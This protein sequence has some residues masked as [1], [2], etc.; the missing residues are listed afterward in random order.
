MIK[1]LLPTNWI[2]YNLQQIITPLIEAKVAIGTLKNL[3][4]QRSWVENLQELELKREIAGTS[5]IEGAD[6]TEKEFEIALSE[7]TEQLLTRSQKQASAAQKAYKWIATRPL[8]YPISK[9]L[10]NNIHRLIVKDVDDDHCKPGIIRNQDENV[11]YGQPRHRGATG[12]SECNEAFSN[13][14]LAIQ[15]DFKKHDPLI[16]AFAAHYHLA[17]IHPYQDGNGRT[18]RA[19]EALMLQRAGL[20]DICFVPM[21]NYYFDEK[22]TYLSTLAETRSNNHDLTSFIKFGLNGIKI[23]TARIVNE[24]KIMNQKGLY[25]N[26]MYDLFKR[27][28]NKKRR[29]IVT[30]QIE[31]LKLLL[32]HESIELEDAYKR[33]E[34][35]YSNLKTSLTSFTRDLGELIHLGAITYNSD[36]S[37]FH[38]NL[39]WPMEMS[40]TELYEK[41]KNL[42]KAKT[43]KFL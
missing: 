16:Q 11:T 36:N 38:I 33:L 2:Y 32:E 8:D 14:V 17:A 4:Q 21:S 40:E 10:I 35:H 41:L 39:N 15:S 6:F 42:P 7:S 18:T 20:K 24:I 29:V 9:E 37:T 22:T 34:V 30:R 28:K 27:L 25:R 43:T 1:Y 3:P 5:K 23:Q 19:L 31:F 12:G 26:F 13:L